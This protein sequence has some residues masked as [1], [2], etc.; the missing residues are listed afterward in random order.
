M[1]KRINA[2]VTFSSNDFEFEDDYNIE[3][4]SKNFD[5]Q[6][7][8]WVK[9]FCH[10]NDETAIQDE[11][12]ILLNKINLTELFNE[13]HDYANK[14]YGFSLPLQLK[15][16]DDTLNMVQNENIIFINSVM[17]S[18]FFSYIAT[19]MYHADTLGNKEEDLFCYR[20]TLSILNYMCYGDFK[21]PIIIHNQ[22]SILA[23]LEKFLDRS[24]L[25]NLTSDIY[26]SAMAFAIAHEIAHS[27]LKHIGGKYSLQKEIDADTNAFKMYLNFCDYIQQNHNTS[28][29][30][31]CIQ[32]HTYMAPMYLLE[33]Y[34]VVYYTGSFLC[35][36]CPPVEKYFFD[37]IVKRKES[38]LEVFYN[39]D[40][41]E[42]E[43]PS[44]DLYN[45]YL[46]GQESFL[47]TF[48]ASDRAG[49]LEKVKE[50]NRRKSSI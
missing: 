27:Y 25:L 44:Y 24:H 28:N 46:N 19:Q 14:F 41:G 7:I 43:T 12:S 42:N 40:G 9:K 29:F 8:E 3:I 13:L 23:L 34:Y 45:F 10:T 21:L 1:K 49:L 15:V 5:P 6:T 39:W 4:I 37:D 20:Y 36:H 31:E 2:L 47:R 16:M 18:A 11:I 22:E 48:V 30:S 38:M 26:F 35:P 33:F 50:N 32:S 17:I